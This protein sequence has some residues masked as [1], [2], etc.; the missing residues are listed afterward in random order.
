MSVMR[1]QHH[2]NC[3][4]RQILIPLLFPHAVT[5]AETAV[6]SA[7]CSDSLSC[8]QVLRRDKSCGIVVVLLMSNEPRIK[9]V[10]KYLNYGVCLCRCR[11]L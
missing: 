10:K 11:A 8:P 3:H 2:P 1:Q 5:G 9:N 7:A 4:S 6:T